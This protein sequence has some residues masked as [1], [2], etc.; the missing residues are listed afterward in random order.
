MNLANLFQ[1]ETDTINL[2][3]GET[4]FREGDKA[5]LFYILLDG[6]LDIVV[7]GEVI[8]TTDRGSILGE[9]ALIDDSPRSATAIAKSSCRLV[10]VDRKRFQFLVQQTPNFSIII[11]KVL[12]DRLRRMDQRL[13]AAQKPL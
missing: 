1:Q 9:M 11:M 4:L 2:S 12:V 6:S 10:G 5:D 8:E 3:L 7:G 13:F